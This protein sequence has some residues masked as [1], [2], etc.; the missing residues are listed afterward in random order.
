MLNS[1]ISDFKKVHVFNLTRTLFILF[2]YLIVAGL[3]LPA[4]P[5]PEQRGS[6]HIR[7]ATAVGSY[8]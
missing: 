5:G 4:R 1:Y 2:L 7:G 6:H 3:L 8:E